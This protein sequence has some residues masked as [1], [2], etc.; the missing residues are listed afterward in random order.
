MLNGMQDYKNTLIKRVTGGNRM[1][2]GTFSIGET[3]WWFLHVAAI[4]GVYA[5]GAKM[6]RRDYE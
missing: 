4:A 2:P 6:T 3:G 1:D 5:L